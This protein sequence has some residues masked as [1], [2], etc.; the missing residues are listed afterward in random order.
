MAFLKKYERNDAFDAL[1]QSLSP[2]PGFPVPNKEY[3]WVSQW[4]GKE[5]QNLVKIVL[6]VLKASLFQPST[7]QCF[8]FRQA[9]SGKISTFT[10]GGLISSLSPD[11]PGG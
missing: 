4:Q 6:P 3:T 10:P 7:E 11:H 5:M 1:W 2:Y 8:H 9:T